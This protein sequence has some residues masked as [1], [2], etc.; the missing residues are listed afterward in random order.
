[1]SHGSHEFVNLC[2]PQVARPVPFPCFGVLKKE[3]HVLLRSVADV[4][5]EQGAVLFC[6]F[7][8]L[9]HVVL[10]S[11]YLFGGTCFKPLSLYL[12]SPPDIH[13]VL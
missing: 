10:V 9:D 6:I 8:N 1:M 13:I 4:V 5:V 12:F 7:S 11:R 2:L 3:K